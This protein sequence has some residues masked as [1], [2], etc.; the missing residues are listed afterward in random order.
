MNKKMKSFDM[1][2]IAILTIGIASVTTSCMKEE[3]ALP[4]NKESMMETK[5]LP[6]KE[7]LN[8][9]AKALSIRPE[10][11]V[12]V[13]YRSGM[14]WCEDTY[15]PNG[16]IKT[17]KWGCNPP[18][19][20]ACC[21]VVHVRV[22]VKGSEK[23]TNSGQLTNGFMSYRADESGTP[24]SIILVFLEDNLNDFGWVSKDSLNLQEDFPLINSNLIDGFENNKTVF[25]KKGNYS[26]LSIADDFLYVE[27]PITA[28][29]FIEDIPAE[30]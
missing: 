15:W 17:H 19:D 28:L 8:K 12:D 22:G 18:T 7:T 20:G 26:L 29:S 25:V 6:D 3:A 2:A 11:I 1:I 5:K 30:L 24:Q 4:V 14:Y 27:I 9:L 10:A 16:K 21:T 23:S 13:E